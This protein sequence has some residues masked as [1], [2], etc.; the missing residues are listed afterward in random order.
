MNSRPIPN[1]NLRISDAERQQVADLLKQHA[2]DGRL[3]Q[4]E[5][6]ARLERTL[7][8]KTRGDLA[9]LL[10]DLPDLNAPHGGGGWP[11][12]Y[13]Y[14]P[15]RYNPGPYPPGSYAPGPY[16]PRP[17]ARSVF[18]TLVTVALVVIAFVAT[19]SAIAHFAVF[20]I[21]WLLILIA[22]VLIW[23]RGRWHHRWR[24]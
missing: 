2:A 19:L 11:G 6:E 3:D 15:G 8:A 23:R 16:G 9:G 20:R 12:P 7:S 14:G 13:G 1:P 18:S 22:C 17:P 5:F 21:P 10:D 4:V 24:A